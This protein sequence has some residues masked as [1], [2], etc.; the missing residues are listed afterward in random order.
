ML[1]SRG[2]HEHH[3]IGSI[4]K[5]M[6]AILAVTHLRLNRVI[7]ISPYAA[8]IQGSTMWLL[9]GDRVPVRSLLL[10][11]LLMPSANDAAEQFAESMA[12]NDR[13]FEP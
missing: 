10:Y 8:S 1:L 7:T 2:A 5:L 13:K 11:G 6:T 9:A 3:A 12:G 4:T